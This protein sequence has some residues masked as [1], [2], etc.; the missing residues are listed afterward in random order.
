MNHKEWGK[1]KRGA[2]QAATP[3]FLTLIHA[4][5]AETDFG[6]AH[7]GDTTPGRLNDPMSTN[8]GS[9]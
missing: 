9:V 1:E 7:R 8:A 3:R 2:E 5:P 6:G 4:K